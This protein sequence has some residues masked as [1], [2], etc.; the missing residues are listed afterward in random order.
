M[1]VVFRKAV[2]SLVTAVFYLTQ[3]SFVYTV[4]AHSAQAAGLPTMSDSTRQSISKSANSWGKGVAGSFKD[5]QPSWGG[6]GF[7]FR[8]GGNSYTINKEDLSPSPGSNYS[9]KHSDYDEQQNLWNDPDKMTDLG[10][11]QKTSLFQAAFQEDG[12]WKTDTTIEG[13]AYSLLVDRQR[14]GN[15]DLS[16]D[17][18]F[19]RAQDVLDN[20]KEAIEGFVN[21]TTET[22]ITHP[23]QKQWVPDL[24]ECSRIV[25]KSAD[26]KVKHKYPLK[27]I[28]H[29]AGPMNI[30]LCEGEPN[31]INIWIGIVD[32]NYRCSGETCRLWED[33]IRFKVLYPEL[34]SKAV[35][36]YAAYDDYQQV[37]I[38]KE[39]HERLIY[40][41]PKSPFPF[42]AMSIG[43]LNG[44]TGAR[45]GA[46]QVCADE[47]TKYNTTIVDTKEAC[48]KMDGEATLIPGHPAYTPPQGSN[49]PATPAVPDKWSCATCAK[50]EYICKNVA[51]RCELSTHW[52]FDPQRRGPTEGGG[53]PCN[54]RT[55][56][57]N[58]SLVDITNDF[59]RL[60]QDNIVRFVARM[61][62][63]GC[64]ESF[65]SIKIYLNSDRI[66]ELESWVNAECMDTL[67]GVEDGY[68]TGS[69]ECEVMPEV[70]GNGCTTSNG[71]RI[72]PGDF[73]PPPVD[74]SKYN[75][76]PLCQ[77]IHV[78][79]DYN[80]YKGDMGCWQA[81]VGVRTDENGNVVFEDREV[82]G[83]EV[84]G[85]ETNGCKEYE[86]RENAKE[87]PCKRV[88]T[89]C[90]REM[91]LAGGGCCAEGMMGESG[92]C[93]VEDFQY[94]CG[95]WVEVG[96]DEQETSTNCSGIA[97][98]GEECID[99]ERSTNT[100]FGKISA[101]M[102]MVDMAGEDM[103][104]DLARY[105]TMD[106]CKIFDG[107]AGKC[108]KGKLFSILGTVNCCKD[109]TNI[110]PMDYVSA[111]FQ[112]QRLHSRV[113]SLNDRYVGG[114]PT[115]GGMAFNFNTGNSIIDG[116]NSVG[117]SITGW[118]SETF[119][120]V[121]MAIADST[122]WLGKSF[123]T[124][125]DNTVGVVTKAFSE[126]YGAINDM[127]D[128]VKGK[129]EAVVERAVVKAV[130]KTGQMLGNQAMQNTARSAANSFMG[131]MGTVFAVVGA[132]YTAI[133]I[134]KIIT[135]L[136]FKCHKDEYILNG[137][138]EAKNC[139]YVGNY[140]DK[141][142]K[143]FKVKKCIRWR[144][145]YCCY[146][147]PLARIVNEQLRAHQPEVLGHG[148]GTPQNPVC[149]GIPV[150]RIEMIDWD[151]V[152]LSEWTAIVADVQPQTNEDLTEE[153]LTGASSPTNI[154]DGSED[155]PNRKSVSARA[156]DA[157]EDHDVD[158]LRI[159]TA[160]CMSLYLGNGQYSG[161]TCVETNHDTVQCRENGKLVS[162]DDVAKD[163]MLKDLLGNEDRKTSAEYAEEGVKCYAQDGRP[164]QCETLYD[165]SLAK[166]VLEEYAA[167]I[168]G[169]TYQDK[170][171]CTD[172]SG[173][174]TENI[175]EE[176]IKAN[177]C[178]CHEMT[179]AFVCRNGGAI[180]D[181]AEL[182]VTTLPVECP[183]KCTKID[184][185][186]YV[187]QE[188]DSEDEMLKPHQDTLPQEGYYCAPA[189]D[190]DNDGLSDWLIEKEPTCTEPG[191]KYRVR[192]ATGEV[193]VRQVVTKICKDD[194]PENACNNKIYCQW[195]GTVLSGTVEANNLQCECNKEPAC[196]D[197]CMAEGK[198]WGGRARADGT[199]RCNCFN[200]PT[201]SACEYGGVPKN[202]GTQDCECT[203]DV[204]CNAQC[205][206][207]GGE[208]IPGTDKCSCFTANAID[209][210]KLCPRFGGVPDPGN[211]SCTC[212]GAPNCDA[213]VC[214]N[215]GEPSEDGTQG[216]NC[217]EIPTDDDCTYICPKGGKVVKVSG[218]YDCACN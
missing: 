175:C 15:I 71:L 21:C 127:V 32:N 103:Q 197:V 4:A 53:E 189:L 129:I 36:W 141:W 198:M 112:L 77:Q 97:C 206:N 167:I 76:S 133:S 113:M 126:V 74:L 144:Y 5:N 94:D 95:H 168:G 210:S 8:A 185:N 84:T 14:R 49:Q 192:L 214:P 30:K 61:A 154:G 130:Q 174:H 57:Q 106:N 216:C 35:F 165:E 75:I 187:C 85:G 45:S 176:A 46:A 111:V 1:N 17:T 139:H 156:E 151:L 38:G 28:E 213:P 25:D 142:M 68:A 13:K 83:G 114:I 207:G 191:V 104:C 37:W 186:G 69:V 99:V 182:G 115:E 100:N 188:Y 101:L 194:D 40:E 160:R 150:S 171:V 67:V 42:P 211:E 116:I 217:Y 79:S 2:C 24:H 137:K 47:C 19:Q 177:T 179:E 39:D 199:N 88:E 23:R 6:N 7:T 70:D 12:T 109:G 9:T 119:G 29:E 201:C 54:Y 178:G 102:Q 143:F 163:N 128:L 50:T 200:K 59:K 212:H 27:V 131:A 89:D 138:R 93:Y 43:R 33:E 148:W 63:D 108:K 125:Y 105:G 90:P 81:T 122:E 195:G 158:Q 18:M 60:D 147:S 205:P 155:S 80:H 41:G 161:G 146:Q 159:Q 215:G 180:I 16:K 91:R 31:C 172:L 56:T 98:S 52:C 117:S 157:L 190:D 166:D 11:Q 135:G 78:V 64:G 164:I 152:D 169:T 162:C 44:A 58:S 218:G 26:C 107:E 82:C 136:L 86:E 204:D 208:P 120:S 183:D 65:A 51:G 149:D 123:M 132:I 118:Y 145:A 209:C 173:I 134:G 170:Y 184:V 48:Q 62:G 153:K 121:Q 10:N 3:S 22:T 66:N 55:Q 181:C 87:K 140:C 124:L 34:I 193:A 110:G 20:L 202:D 196:S 96:T 73:N 92:T 203:A 72:C